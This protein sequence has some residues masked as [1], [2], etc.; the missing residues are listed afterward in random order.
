MTYGT[1]AIICFPF[2]LWRLWVVWVREAKQKGEPVFDKDDRLEIVL[3]SIALAG[4]CAALW[5]LTILMFVFD[6]MLDLVWD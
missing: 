5:P 4:V 3:T 2:I 1:I 6:K